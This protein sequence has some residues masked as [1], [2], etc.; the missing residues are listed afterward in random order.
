MKSCFLVLGTILFIEFTVV[1]RFQPSFYGLVSLTLS[2]GCFVYYFGG[3]KRIEEA[4]RSQAFVYAFVFFTGG[5]VIWVVAQVLS[6]YVL[7]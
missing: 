3:G 4:S 1:L 7:S 2:I 6:L 5:V